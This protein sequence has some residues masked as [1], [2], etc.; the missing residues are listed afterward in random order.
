[1]PHR[2]RIRFAK[3]GDLR[4]I[5]H[6][7]LVRLWERIFRRANVAL[8]MSQG[9]HPKAR[10]SIPVALP[11][12]IIGC[13]ELLEVQLADPVPPEVLRE[14]LAKEAPSGLVVLSVEELPARAPKAQVV[15]TWYELQVPLVH[16]ER[17]AA[18]VEK[19]Q[20]AESWPIQRQEDQKWI[21]VRADVVECRWEADR[22]VFALRHHH[23][24]AT[25]P[26]DL[27]EVLGLVDETPAGLGLKRT[28][29]E[30]ASAPDFLAGMTGKEHVVHEKRDVD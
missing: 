3:T 13:R 29:I 24:A 17:V 7:D 12:G 14:L 23:H 6:H 25:R 15:K 2:Y 11:L 18:L 5:G 4:W 8:A 9:F 20:Q 30:L 28:D 19:L 21:D 27:L 22:L 10:L 26:R 16:R 1:M